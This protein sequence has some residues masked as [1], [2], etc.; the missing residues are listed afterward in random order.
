MSMLLSKLV[1]D[2]DGI[3][4]SVISDG[5]G[6]N[7]KSLS[8]SINDKLLLATDA[9]GVV[10]QMS[11]ELEFSGTGT[12]DDLG[13]LDGSSDDHDS[14]IERSFSFL[15]E[16]FSTSSNNESGGL[17]LWKKVN[18]LTFSKEAIPQGS[19]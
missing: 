16:L 11:G 14:I 6:D 2:S 15:N 19:L 13:G 17:A 9:S 7:F 10:K 1:Q 5:S 18:F 8:E 4:T 3:Q 12:S